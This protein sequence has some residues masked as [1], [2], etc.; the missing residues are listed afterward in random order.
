MKSLLK[1]AIL[2]S[3]ISSQTVIPSFCT[4]TVQV[5]IYFQQVER[6]IDNK[7]IKMMKNIGTRQWIDQNETSMKVD[8]SKEIINALKQKDYDK[9]IEIGNNSLHYANY[10]SKNIVANYYH[11]IGLSYLKKMYYTNA[12]QYF[13]IAIDKYNKEHIQNSN[14]YYERGLARLEICDYE[15]AKEDFNKALTLGLK[16][17]EEHL[18]N[19]DE[20]YNYLKDIKCK[21]NDN[22]SILDYFLMPDMSRYGKLALISDKIK[23]GDNENILDFYYTRIRHNSKLAETYNNIGVYYLEKQNYQKA[24]ECFNNALKE[25]SNIIEPYYNL[26]LLYYLN[27]EY[28]KAQ[29]NLIKYESFQD[30]LNEKYIVYNYGTAINYKYP[31]INTFIDDMLKANIELKLRNYKFANEIYNKYKLSNF[32]DNYSENKYPIDYLPLFEGLVY[33]YIEL[34][35][36]KKAINNL[37]NMQTADYHY[38]TD[39]TEKYRGKYFYIIPPTNENF[40]DFSNAYEVIENSYILSNIALLEFII[41]KQNKAIEDINRAKNLS[42][43]FNNIELYKQIIRTYNYIIYNNK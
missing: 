23:K 34:G 13:N 9:A 26:A 15:G 5:N 18:I 32:N 25:N 17:S 6:N 8:Y 4:D 35:K 42:F 41:G 2:L 33:Q 21:N 7:G 29:E 27:E 31:Q 1:T 37:V 24:L 39:K 43:N 3:F 20:T 30:K 19:G 10:V 28:K 14:I 22:F 38:K 16:I 11:Y 36:Y 40:V 12:I